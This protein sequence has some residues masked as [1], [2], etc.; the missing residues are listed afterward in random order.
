MKMQS[1]MQQPLQVWCWTCREKQ[2]I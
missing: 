1:A 2:F